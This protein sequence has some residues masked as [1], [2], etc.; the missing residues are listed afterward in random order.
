MKSVTE[1]KQLLLKIMLYF[2]Y[3][4]SSSLK[5]NDYVYTITKINEKILICM[6]LLFIIFLYKSKV[7][8]K[9]VENLLLDFLLFL[10]STVSSILYTKRFLD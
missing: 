9:R 10:I 4:G 1:D 7:K 5:T 6:Y 3:I 2:Y 8:L